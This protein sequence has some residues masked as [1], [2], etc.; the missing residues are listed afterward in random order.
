MVLIEIV[1]VNQGVPLFALQECGVN[2]ATLWAEAHGPIQ[3]SAER[4]SRT[5]TA[6]LPCP[7]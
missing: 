1:S 7:P 6:V 3:L 5:P 2:G 4:P